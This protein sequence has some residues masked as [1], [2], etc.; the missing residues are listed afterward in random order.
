MSTHSVC[1]LSTFG[2]NYI[3]LTKITFIEYFN[4]YFKSRVVNGYKTQ[5]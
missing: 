4:S 2:G 5:Q 1:S 3:K